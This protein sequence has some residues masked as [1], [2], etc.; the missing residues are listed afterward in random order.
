[1]KVELTPDAAQWVEAE[2]AAGRFPTAE[3]AVRYAVNYAKL[4]GLRGELEAAEREG[5]SFTTDEVRR[6]A[7]AHLDRVAGTPRSRLFRTIK[8]HVLP[9]ATRLFALPGLSRIPPF[10]ETTGAILQSKRGGGYAAVWQEIEGASNFV[11]RPAPVIFDIGANIGNWASALLKA[12]PD[13]RKVVVFEPQASCWPSLGRVCGKRVTVERKAVSDTR[14]TL[15]LWENPNPEISSV[16]EGLGGSPG[17]RPVEVETITIDEYVASGEIDAVDY[18]KI[19][20]EGHEMAVIRGA[21]R[22]IEQGIVRA[23]S[24]EFGQ[25]DIVSR[26][27]F[28]DFWQYLTD[29]KLRI[30]RLG[31]DGRAIHV[32]RYSYDLES[33]SGVAN[34]VA[35][36][37]EPKRTR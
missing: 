17:S 11:L 34:Y 36:F 14:G 21:R 8:K 22:S 7:R 18:M 25:A 19:D 13:A 31:H 6:Y 5:G 32:P 23:L 30:Y 37:H 33:F 4:A 28:C 12:M 16:Y 2:L 9:A 27:F 29:L 26:T 20:V 15:I 24:F 35:S 3:D 1:M 10:L